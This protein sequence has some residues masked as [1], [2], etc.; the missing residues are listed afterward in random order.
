MKVLRLGIVS[1]SHGNLDG[2]KLAITSMLE[3]E[4]VDLFIHLGDDFDDAL[5]FEEYEQKYLRVPGVFSDYYRH[6]SIANR[7][8]KEFEGWCFLLSHTE[9]S[10]P[11]DLPGDPKPEDLISNR[12]VDVVLHGHT[13]I[14]RLESREGILFVNPG[15]LKVKDKKG[16]PPSY[17]VVEVA[18]DLIR[19]RIIGLGSGSEMASIEITRDRD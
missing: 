4:P 10:H 1:D 11:N 18:T 5:I 9:V 15:H 8:I 3:D 12:Q 19:G 2:L 17:A 6:R 7:L 16:M 13:H 14:P